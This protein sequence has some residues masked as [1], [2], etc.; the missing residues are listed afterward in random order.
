[1][2]PTVSGELAFMK[3]TRV[4]CAAGCTTPG[5]GCS[6]GRVSHAASALRVAPWPRGP[7]RRGERCG[8]A[9]AGRQSSVR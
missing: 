5:G 6:E 9:R 4:E 3:P 8:G 1:M 7:E 2:S